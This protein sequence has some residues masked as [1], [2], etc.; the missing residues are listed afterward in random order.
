[1]IVDTPGIFDTAHTNEHTQTEIC[2][3]I[4][5]TSPGPH[6]FILVLSVSRFTQEEQNTIDHFIK[7]FGENIYKYAIVLFTRKDDLDEE[8]KA[9]FDHIKTSPAQLQ[10]LVKKCGGRVIAFN[11]RLKEDK[12]DAQVKELLD[13]ISKNVERNGDK[14]YTN[15]MFEEA[16]KILRKREKEIA[17]KA[18][19]EHEK[20]LK[21]I[22]EKIAKSYEIRHEKDAQKLRAMEQQ[23][24]KST[25]THKQ[26]ERKIQKLMDQVE[27]TKE[28]LK[29]SKGKDKEYFQSNLAR[30][31]RDLDQTKANEKRKALEIQELKKSKDAAEKQQR[32]M[33][34]NQKKESMK[35]KKEMQEKY[36]R[37]IV[38]V[39]DEVRKEVEEG[40]N[41]ITKTISRIKNFFG[42]LW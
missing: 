33:I 22:E 10:M 21:A 9:I 34:K 8:G 3:C 37:K 13:E 24:F 12:Q 19:E 14:C 29:E 25:N 27:E 42:G 2:K 28:Q 4:A 17:S 18:K 1:M 41:I 38:A 31:Q 20:E 40:G 15:E 36:D 11:N 26:A 6:A 35:L 7:H 39:R 23:L 30:L 16:E 5:I 32:E